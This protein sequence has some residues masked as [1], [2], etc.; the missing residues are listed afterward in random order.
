MAVIRDRALASD[1]WRRV[2]EGGDPWPGAEGCASHVLL[3]LSQWREHRDSVLAG[4]ARVGVVLGADEAVEE[5]AADL[6]RLDLVAFE[7]GS[8]TEG[9]CYSRAGLLRERYRFRGEIRATGDVS[10]DRLAFMERSG[11]NAFELREDC[12]PDT[13]LSAFDEVSDVYQ[14]GRDGA[15]TI[16]SR[17]GLRST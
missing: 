7:F 1:P 10:T 14:P 5:I 9:R 4:G 13:A 17:R 8:V 6:E 3:S 15:R 11:F 12:D 16:S 2:P